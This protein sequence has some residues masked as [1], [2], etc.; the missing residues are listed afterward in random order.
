MG[1]NGG[2]TLEPATGIGHFFGKRP[3]NLPIEM[4]GIEL[5]PVSGRI[6]QQLYQSADIKITG[7]ED[8]RLQ[9]NRYNLI[10]SNVP[11]GDYKPYEEK[12]NRTPGLDN[13]SSIHDFYFLKSLYGLREGGLIAF[14]TSRYTLD[15]EDTAIRERIAE[16]ADFIGAIRL[17]NNAFKQI[18]NT[19]VVTDV[20][21]LQKR[22]EDQEMSD[23]TKKFI[24][25][26]NILIPD[27][28]DT[29][30]SFSIN[31]YF[32]DHPEM[33][34]GKHDIGSMY[35][36]KDYTVSLSDNDLK[37]RI[38]AAISFLPENIM[39]VI[40]NEKT[41]HLDDSVNCVFSHIDISAIPR[42]SF[43]VG[44]DNRLYQKSF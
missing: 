42:G 19:E 26:A 35:S 3:H 11:F 23:Q 22:P 24:H 41:K 30:L 44:P 31:Q 36:G 18:A 28:N 39:N 8:V 25:T 12:Q 29:N 1:Y 40:V 38:D 34:I 15:K 2:P 43:V 14:I 4:H 21:F 33:V 17:P 10:I 7:Y 6:A 16:K 20:V 32:I 27:S 9:E 13:R 5:D 37:R